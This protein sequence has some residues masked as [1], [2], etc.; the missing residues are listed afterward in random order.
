M[1][2]FEQLFISDAGISKIHSR[3]LTVPLRNVGKAPWRLPGVQVTPRLLCFLPAQV[4]VSPGNKVKVWRRIT[5][6]T[7]STCFV[8]ATLLVVLMKLRYSSGSHRSQSCDICYPSCYPGHNE[9]VFI[10]EVSQLC[11]THS[12][13]HSCPE[14][15]PSSGFLV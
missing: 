12:T 13:Y 4:I 6:A 15:I 5:A 7:Y 9:S 2:H 1:E 10:L 8:V 14:F 3:R 11:P